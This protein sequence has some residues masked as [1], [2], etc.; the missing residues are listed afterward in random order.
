ML[1]HSTAAAA[2]YSSAFAESD[3][4][5]QKQTE[6]KFQMRP[7][8][9]TIDHAAQAQAGFFFV[10]VPVG[11]DRFVA[12]EVGKLVSKA[13]RTV[14]ALVD[15]AEKGP[16]DT[17]RTATRF[18]HASYA[19]HLFSLCGITRFDYMCHHIP[20][21]IMDILADRIQTLLD[22]SFAK[23]TGISTS[24]ATHRR[25][26]ICTET[27]LRLSARLGRLGVPDVKV[28]SPVAYLSTLSATCQIFYPVFFT[29]I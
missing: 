21:R 14:R 15:F 10:G 9:D 6:A 3:L 5:Q 7:S 29:I 28:L 22:R 17:F 11:T 4:L 23:I 27:F 24:L 8:L 25:A 26:N 12:R 1:P 20:P 16:L 13:E 18:N 19:M 2:A